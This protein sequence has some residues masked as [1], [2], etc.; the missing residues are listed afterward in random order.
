MAIKEYKTD[1]IHINFNIV[2]SDGSY[3]T[4]GQVLSRDAGG[5][6]WADGSGSGIIGG[7]YLPL[8]GG[9]MTGTG[10]IEMPDNF[11]L[12][13][14]G[15]IFKIFNDGTYSIIRSANEPLL[16]DANDITFRGYAPYNSLM[17]I[18]SSGN[19]GIGTTSP[20]YKLEVNG[21]TTLVGG[22]FHVSTDQTIIT[23][24]SYTF[25]D[26]V[27]INNPNSSSAAASSTAVMSI[28]AMTS[29]TSLITTGNVGIGTTAPSQK[30]QVNG[31]IRIP[32]NASN[33][34]YFGQD[35]GSIGY[36]SMHPFDNLGNY[37]FDT[38]YTSTGSYKFK[39]NG[40]E[41]FRLRNTGAFSFGSAGNDYGVSGQILTSAGNASPTWTTPTTGTVTGTG[42]ATQVAFW[43]GTSSL[44]GSNGLY[45][46]NTNGHLGIGDTTPGSKLRVVT[47]TSETSI[48]TVDILHSRNNP[49]VATNAVRIDVN[50]SGADNTTAD[51]INSGL[52]LDIDSSADGDASDEHRIYGV[53]S[54]VRFTGF[55]D[56]VRGGYFLAESNNITEKTAQLVGVFGNA[57]H[58]ASSTSGG[59]TNMYGVYGISSIQ[60]LG[61]VDNAFGG[62]FL[63]QVSSARGNANVGVTKGVEGRVSIDKATT[64]SYG[65]MTA[66]SGVIDNNEGTVPTF[67][68]Q[69]LFKGDYQGTKGGNAYG[70]YTEGDKHY[71]EGNVGIGTTSPTRALEVVK[72]DASN[73]LGVFDSNSSIN[74]Q[75]AFSDANSTAGQYSTRIGSIGDGLGFWTNGSSQRMCIDSAGNVGI[76]TS[77]PVG[78]LS[79]NEA[80]SGV[81]FTRSSGDN[82]TNNPVIAF[83]NDTT[84][85]IIATAGDGLIFR[86]RAVGGAV[87][88]G[89]EAMRITSGGNVGIGT[90]SPGA[91]LQVGTRGTAGALTPPTTD[92]I[93]F[94]FHNDGSPYTRHAA[95][96]SQAGDTTEAVIDFWTKPLNG[97]NSKKMTLR[98]DGNVGIGITTPTSKLHVTQS[99]TNP[100]LDLPQSFAVE[101]DSN[102]SGSAATT[103]DRE[104]G[105][106]FIDVDSSTT[107]G[108]ATNEHRLYGIYNRVN[109][110]GD[111]DLVYGSSNVAE[112]NTT[113]GTTATIYGVNGM[114]I[115]DGGANAVLTTMIG[116]YGA[117]SMQDATPVNNSYGGN[118]LNNS[119][120]N[121]TGAT[122]NTYG[123]KSEIQ[124]D[125]TSAFTNLYAGRFTID[126]NATYTATSSYLLYLD[127]SGTSLATNTYAIYSPDDVKSYHKGNFGINTNNPQYNLHV[128]GNARITGA[129][130]DTLNSPG[131]PGQVLS[132]TVNGT[133]WVDASSG[134]GIG[135]S[136][137]ATEIAF[138]SATASEIDSDPGLTYTSGGGLN[139]G[140]TTG[141]G[142]SVI[143]MKKGSAG[144]SRFRMY[145][146]VT[147]GISNGFD[148][149]LDGSEN[150]SISTA[151]KLTIATGGSQHIILSPAGNVGIGTTSPTSYKLEVTGTGGFTS[152]VTASNFILSSDKRLKNNIKNIDDDHID[153]DWKNFELKSEPGI[154]RSGVIAQELEERHPEFVRTD[155]EGLKSVAY[156]DLLIAKIAELEARLEKAGI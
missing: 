156:I 93:L 90:T 100:D 133:D 134:G 119:I 86:T 139:V 35:N 69:Y 39:Y 153:V 6:T 8:A 144:I 65:E 132:S 20:S 106:L 147:G 47:T 72:T 107:G 121:R 57:V 149:T 140:D 54:D 10:S 116:V 151:Q 64:I 77:S 131:T 30:L 112:Q 45:W 68:N 145:Y 88:S 94:D 143:S 49:D 63:T 155:K 78:K 36:G 89:G 81:F 48:Y 98:G 24:S 75:I 7:P 99:V 122:T 41:I 51:R 3:G 120:S 71:F 61:D 44:S 50:L 135:G 95:I 150:T 60:D 123:I 16:I 87:F 66:V 22:G 103:S 113:T 101:I 2:D 27:Y 104:Q 97:S 56:N 4:S 146:A 76:G 15:G 83:A 109:H 18:K 43:D 74:T 67:G 108:D 115:S 117:T 91:K 13:L 128:V 37:T 111:A 114:A 28:G 5:V 26:G 70:I 118:F 130:Y 148:I 137:T 42:A 138:G 9:T 58:D 38:N 136:T 126:S 11:S 29:G 59:V 127:Y 40:T 102:H 32:Y 82:G 23:S 31:R 129:Y 17:T 21:G 25:R 92:G 34:Y 96:I 33:L 85:S 73:I 105:G 62:F 141:S 46:D 53:Y 52:F 1:N 110:T 55:S 124:I 12:L 80:G 79:V 14:G 154:K 152:T 142:N 125:S 19:V 84:K